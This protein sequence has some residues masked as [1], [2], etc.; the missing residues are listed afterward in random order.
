[1]LHNNVGSPR[2]HVD[3]GL[4]IGELCSKHVLLCYAGIA[5][6]TFLLC[7]WLC[8]TTWHSRMCSYSIP[9]VEL[10]TK[11]LKCAWIM[12]AQLSASSPS[13][14]S[15]YIQ[16]P[17]SSDLTRKWRTFCVTMSCRVMFLHHALELSWNYPYYASIC[18][19]ARGYLLCS[20]LCW[21]NSLMPTRGVRESA[22][23]KARVS[24]KRTFIS[25]GC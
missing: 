22:N 18:S 1:M 6:E 25:Y 13:I 19:Y 17:D 24:W 16:A 9:L 4:G 23:F 12:A 10:R 20:K 15:T 7:P 2:V 11:W 21:H 8:S 14:Q 5:S 3:S